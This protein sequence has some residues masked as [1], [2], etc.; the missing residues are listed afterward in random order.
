MQCVA[1]FLTTKRSFNLHQNQKPI[2]RGLIRLFF[3]FPF[4]FH[5]MSV[6]QLPTR[7][8]VEKIIKNFHAKEGYIYLNGQTLQERDDTDVELPFR[9]ESNFFYVTGVTEP[10]FHVVIDLSTNKITLVSPNLDP[11]AVMWMGLPDTLDQLKEKY[12]ID[13][14]IYFDKLNDILSSAPVVYTLPITKTD[15]LDKSKVKLCDQN[16]SK[17]L[18]SA[19]VEARAIKAD[20]EIEIIRKA[21]QISS[22][23]H[24]KVIVYS[25]EYV[26]F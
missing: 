21:N 24:M 10:N 7:Q 22:D 17:L 16:E 23:A 12:D 18:Y 26:S 20:W 3:F 2:A 6:T 15:A 19:F 11:D 9:Q 25:S 5:T 1:F 4:L 13:E 14:A 8:N